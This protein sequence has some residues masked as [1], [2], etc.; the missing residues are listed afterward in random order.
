MKQLI[1]ACCLLLLG[2]GGFAQFSKASLQASG[3]T[4]ALC[5]KAINNSLEQLSFIKSVQPDIKSSS[6]LIEFKEGAAVDIDALRKGVEDAGFSVAKL[7]LT[8][9]FNALP[10]EPDEHATINGTTFHFL[11]VKKQVIS[12][13]QV[14]TLVDKSFLPAK[15]FKKYSKSSSMSCVQTGKAGDCCKKDGVSADTRIYHVTI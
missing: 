13:E 6:F 10:V 15:E 7:Q 11:S 3:L 14:F 5:T 1:I 12:G 8:G 9:Q 2:T 4:C